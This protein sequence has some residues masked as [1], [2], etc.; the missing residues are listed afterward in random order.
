VTGIWATYTCLVIR[1][2]Q[3]N[4]ECVTIGA[5]TYQKRTLAGSGLEPR[6]LDAGGAAFILFW[7]QETNGEDR[8]NTLRPYTTALADML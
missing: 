1:T 4:L 3:N 8:R 7:S 2:C 5:Q 6:I